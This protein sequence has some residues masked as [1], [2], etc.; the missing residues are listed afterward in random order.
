MQ[1]NFTLPILLMKDDKRIVHYIE[2]VKSGELSEVDRK[3]MLQIVRKSDAINESMKISNA[4]LK[5]A[6]KEVEALSDN[7]MK[8]KL[9]D[10]ALFMGKRKF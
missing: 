9:K 1:G 3:N 5:K 10:V 8:K 2:K 7:P 4:Y 6:L